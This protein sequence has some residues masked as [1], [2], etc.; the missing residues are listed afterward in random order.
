MS[1][2][3]LDIVPF[4]NTSEIYVN[5]PGSKSISNR[6]LILSVLNK[7]DI[8][9]HGL[10]KSDDVK[11]MITALRNLGVIINELENSIIEVK[12]T[13][14]KLVEKKAS[15]NVGN[16]GT[17]ARFITALLA[18]QQNGEYYLD[19]SEAMRKRPMKGLIEALEVHGC[20]FDFQE[21]EYHFPFKIICNGLNSDDWLIDASMSSQILSAILM[22]S[23]YING[24]KNI[25]LFGNTVSNHLFR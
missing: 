1:I 13:G 4:N 8:K 16:A 21:K 22:I 5:I 20:K 25:Q 24:K 9:L 23:P 12:G 18:L 17:V 10:L 2:D 15:I 6:A 14:G 7:K 3:S 19:G 11:I